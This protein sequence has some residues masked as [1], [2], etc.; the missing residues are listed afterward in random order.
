MAMLSLKDQIN[1]SMDGNSKNYDLLKWQFALK[2]SNIGIWDFDADANRVFYS[3][4]SKNI[5]GFTNDE[6]GANPNDWNDRVH[7][8]DK[9]KYL[10]DFQNHLEG[11]ETLYKNE[12]RIRCKDGSYKWV[13]DRGKIIEWLDDGTPKRIIGTHTDITERK[14]RETKLSSGLNI[15]TNQNQKLLNFAHIVSHN[16]RTHTGNL[17]SMIEF[18]EESDSNRE[19]LDHF[20]HIKLV[21]K[22]LFDTVNDLEDIVKVQINKAS[23]ETQK[24]NLVDYINQSLNVLKADIK[25]YDASISI[26][27]SES[28]YID[29]LPTYLESILLNLLTNA[30]KYRKE[31]SLLK[32]NI[33]GEETPHNYILKI[34]DNGIGIDLE[35]YGEKLFGMYNTFHNKTEY[36]SR[37]IGLYLTKNQL[38]ALGGTIQVESQ[39]NIGSTFIIKFKK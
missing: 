18:Y 23:L 39:L 36:D 12:H 31:D 30:V 20:S 15:I 29:F 13:L 25:D 35:K 17:N 38:E 21:T 16:L 32:I 7:P 33:T 14:E 27:I 24:L 9:E 4:E 1:F 8:D 34:K 2:N 19:K 3:K 28:I 22:S 6:F 5:I 37:G 11:I 10:K 26:N